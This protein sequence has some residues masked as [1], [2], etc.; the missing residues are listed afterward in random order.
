LAKITSVKTRKEPFGEFSV[1]LH[2]FTGFGGFIIEQ[3]I[4]D[5]NAGKQLSYAAKDV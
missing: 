2:T 5:T 1:I 3:H 4:L